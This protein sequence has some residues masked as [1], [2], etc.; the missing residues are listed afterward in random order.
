MR[1]TKNKAL[2]V[3]ASGQPPGGLVVDVAL[4]TKA[5]QKAGV[6]INNHSRS[7]TII[8]AGSVRTDL[9]GFGVSRS[10][11]SSWLSRPFTPLSTR[12]SWKSLS[13]TSRAKMQIY[14]KYEELLLRPTTESK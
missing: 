6:A 4:V 5:N 1:L 14:F 13:K 7:S 9:P 3:K 8:R 11:S 2:F 12:V 10:N